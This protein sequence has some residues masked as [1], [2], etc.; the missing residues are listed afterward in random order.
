[1]LRH[2]RE[3]RPCDRRNRWGAEV[4]AGDQLWL[5][6]FSKGSAPFVDVEVKCFELRRHHITS[7]P[8]D[9]S[10]TVGRDF[11]PASLR[12]TAGQGRICGNSADH[13]P[14]PP[15]LTQ[16]ARH[17]CDRIRKLTVRFRLPS[18]PRTAADVVHGSD[19]VSARCHRACLRC[20][21]WVR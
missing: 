2:G 5:C 17:T 8:I 12:R 3:H 10:P 6:G 11:D 19:D 4:R 13:L 16:V 15:A 9:Q 21:K 7:Q 18:E 14:R 20:D 1:M